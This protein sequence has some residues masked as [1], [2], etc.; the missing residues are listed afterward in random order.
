MI[1]KKSLEIEKTVLVGLINTKQNEIISNDYLNELEF[2]CFTAG[3]N[4]I[5]RFT[6]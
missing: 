4:V 5:K 2:L 6:Q 1:E 3:G